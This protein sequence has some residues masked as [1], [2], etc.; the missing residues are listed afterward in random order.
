VTKNRAL[1]L[2]ASVSLILA[3]FVVLP[4][5]GADE[6]DKESKD[7]LYRPLGLFTEV[8]S[9]VRSNY[10]EPVEAK[11]LLVGAFSGMTEAMDPFSEYVPPDKMPAFNAARAA[12]EKKEALDV[13]I[14]LARRFN[15]PLVVAAIAGSPASAAGLKSDD[16]LEKVDGQSMRGVALWEVE[17]KLA[18]KAGGRVRLSI[19]RDG[20]PRRHT[21]DVVR[22]TW[23]PD[24]PS[25]TRVE[26]ELL[27]KVPS[28][29]PGTV[30]ALKAILAPL[31][32]T[33]PLLIDLRSNAW[34][35]FEEAAHAAALFTPA[36]PLAELK[37]RRIEGKTFTAEAGERV[38]DS[39]LVLLVDSGTA[40]AAELFAAALR[41][42]A[43]REAGV[44][45]KA[46]PVKKK[47]DAE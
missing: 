35:S 31:D 21:I 29:A 32:R 37:G 41:D 12:R 7:T 9:L 5:L 39:R 34:G 26:G 40:G 16:L 11:P 36:G 15:Y 44:L 43:A 45:V 25:A 19:V 10:V 22:G 6:K 4:G 1:G 46:D 27:V 30:A 24:T 18:G 28:F 38:H 3:I 2:A 33:K 47:A 8:F 23:T 42:A 20:K 17:S 14:V 13:G